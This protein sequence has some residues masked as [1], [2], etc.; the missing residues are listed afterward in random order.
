M[1]LSLYTALEAT[2]LQGKVH[3]SLP[4]ASE[5]WVGMNAEQES[6][7]GIFALQSHVVATEGGSAQWK[8]LK[9]RV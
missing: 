4:P 3:S 1:L 7:I 9:S 2:G 5:E 6:E 8:G